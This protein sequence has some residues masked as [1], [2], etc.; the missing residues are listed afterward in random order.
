MPPHWQLPFNC[1]YHNRVSGFVVGSKYTYIQV[2]CILGHI[3]F[4]YIGILGLY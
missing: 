2:V 3:Y 4:T 1:L